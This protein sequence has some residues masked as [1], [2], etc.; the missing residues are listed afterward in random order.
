MNDFTVI[1]TASSVNPEV[2]LVI[3]ACAAVRRSG[4]TMNHPIMAIGIRKYEV[5]R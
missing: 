5:K 3:P 1:P 4:M 2:V